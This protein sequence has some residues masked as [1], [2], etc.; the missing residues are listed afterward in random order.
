VAWAQRRNA[1]SEFVFSQLSQHRC[2]Q[3]TLLIK[4]SVYLTHLRGAL[5]KCEHN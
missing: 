4:F 2:S 1:T 3:Q 5:C